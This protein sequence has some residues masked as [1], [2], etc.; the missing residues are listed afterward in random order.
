M[1]SQNGNPNFEVRKYGQSFWY[2]N[3]QR[4]IIASGEM[5]ALID[6]YGVLGLT[7]NPAI[8]D[9]AITGSRDYDD[10]ILALAQRG[11]DANAIY[12]ALAIADIQ[13]AADLLEP[14]Y[15][16]TN[17]LDGYVSLE[18]SPLLAHDYEATVNEA[19]RLFQQVGRKNL[20]VKVP[21]T[22]AGIPAIQRLIADGININV[23]LI[24]SLEGYEAVARAYLAG[25]KER[26]MNGQSLEV[27]SVASFFVS[28]VDTLVD[29]LL[30]EKIAALPEHDVAQRERLQAL[31]GKAAIANAKLAYEIF[32]R[33][34]AEPEFKALAERGA[35]V[36]RVLWASTS[37]KNPA[38]KD[39]YYV[40]ALIG[41]HT[42]NTLPPATLKAFRDHGVVAPTL[43][44]GRDEARRTLEALEAAGISMPQVWQ[45]LQDDGVKLF[46]DA[47]ESL[48]KGIETKRAAAVA[49]GQASGV[50]SALGYVEELVKL[51]A[52]S[53][54]WQRDASLWTTAPEHIKVIS[55][56]L[57]WLSVIEAMRPRIDELYAFRDHVRSMGMT[58]AVVL[59]MGG[60]SLAP[61]VMRVT[62]APADGATGLQLHVLDTT[63]PTTVLNLERRLD[64]KK[65]LFIVASKSGST[66]EVNAFYK[67]FRAKMDDIAGEEA[68]QH[69]VAITDEGTS[70]Q[71][72]AAEERFGKVFINPADIGGRYSAL[73]Y[74]GLVPAALQGLDL[75]KL[76]DRAAQMAGWCKLDSAINPGLY[77]GALMGGLALNGRDKVTFI[78]SP[79][80]EAFGYWVEQLIA[81][82]TG[83]QGR[84]IVPVEG[85]LSIHGTPVT[86]DSAALS[87]DRFFVYVKL[88]GDQTYDAFV[89][90][91]V[92]AGLPVLTLHLHDV[93]D[94]GAEFFRW[95]FATA[96]AGVVIGVNPFDEPNVT[97]SKVNTKRLL[98]EFEQSGAFSSEL[99][100]RSA[101]GQL[102]KFLRQAKAGD[103]I[104][105]Q[106]YL[107]YS[108]EVAQLLTRLRHLIREKTGVP[109]TVG[110]GPRFL[111]ST[112]QLHKGGANNVVALQL[113]YDSQEDVL[114]AGEPFSFGT[115][116]RAQALGDFESLKAHQRRVLRLH[117]GADL[118]AALEKVIQVVS[119]GARRSSTSAQSAKTSSTRV[120]A[121][122]KRSSS[123]KRDE[124]RAAAGRS[125]PDGRGFG[126]FKRIA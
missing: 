109:V 97:E 68:G 98:D 114:I 42:V 31:K 44:E 121:G 94:L 122:A 49:R 19:R 37:T 17:G 41:E 64:L 126:S 34:F 70:L 46:A 92:Q 80:I 29:K 84:G 100:S 104:A 35:R 24:F 23:T 69:F 82:S 7:S 8:F 48:L 14:I 67:Y 56:R 105:I 4:N 101:N 95:E 124:S 117:L 63:D 72:L 59:G 115:L 108:D 118:K 73:S 1:T 47:F 65:T 18:V 119:G 36:Q 50:A 79:A 28:R 54:V 120:G 90:N 51:K 5:Q 45:K 66:L 2:D 78:L 93:Y 111:H 112:G 116:I 32:E 25:L 106:A 125:S 76:L 102:N 75:A 57:G 87:P 10:D 71:L 40:E 27:A 38:Y 6:D 13:S 103:Y 61:D 55:N 3:I 52:A 15:E 16:Q 30:D 81:E 77:L 74:F 89:S 123:A 33:I 12:E 107:P 22:P 39:T 113:T 86:L 88:S 110:Y 83:K 85:D 60:S 9:K 53:R 21:A 91:L 62:F 20:M 11:A 58:D 26:A 96:I 99:T 43:R